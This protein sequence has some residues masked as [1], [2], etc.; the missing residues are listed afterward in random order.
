[1]ARRTRASADRSRRRRR[2]DGCRPRLPDPRPARRT[3]YD[4]RDERAP[5]LLGRP[6]SRPR[7]RLPH[8]RGA[9]PP[10]HAADAAAARRAAARDRLPRLSRRAAHPLRALAR[11]DAPDEPPD[12]RGQPEPGIASRRAARH[13]PTRGS[14]GPP[15]SS[16]TSPTSRRATTSR[17]CAA[18]SSATTRPAA[19]STP[20]PP[21]PRSARRS[22]RWACAARSSPSCCRTTSIRRSRHPPLHHLE[23]RSRPSSSSWSRTPSRLC[24]ART[25]STSG[26]R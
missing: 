22:T 3:G 8:R 16:T 26:A 2:R 20:S 9:A 19:T 12:R 15:P 17:T 21:R 23:V 13:A 7:R 4:R 11:D 10:R 5:T 14:C 18:S 6:G 25:T 1:M 24:S